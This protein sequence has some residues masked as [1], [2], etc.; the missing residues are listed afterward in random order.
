M[1]ESTTTPW[2]RQFWP[3]FL[4]ALPFAVVVAGVVTAWLAFKDADGLVV[5]DYYRE[6]RAINQTLDRDRKARELGLSAEIVLHDGRLEVRLASQGLTAQAQPAALRLHLEHPTRSE[7]D[8][9]FLLSRDGTGAYTLL[10]DENLAGA[11]YVTLASV[12]E[13]WR[14]TGRWALPDSKPLALSHKK[15][16]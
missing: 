12:P 15:R 4:F 7:K 14:L 10:V 9:E 2:Y 11:W 8:H 5:D 13:A 16:P 1:N 6:G 3:W